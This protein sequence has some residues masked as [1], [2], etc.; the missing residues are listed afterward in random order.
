VATDSEEESDDYLSACMRTAQ[1]KA[2]EAVRNAS[3]ETSK[4]AGKKSHGRHAHSRTS[5]PTL[6][7]TG[8]PSNLNLSRCFCPI[9]A[10]S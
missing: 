10:V 3:L 7:I 9:M 4:K 2:K 8:D 5:T 1:R 6:D